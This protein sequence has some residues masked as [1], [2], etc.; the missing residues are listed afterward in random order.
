MGLDQLRIDWCLRAGV[1]T[2]AG[3]ITSSLYLLDG[4]MIMTSELWLIINQWMFLIYSY[5]IPHTMIVGRQKNII[6]IA[7][8]T[9]AVFAAEHKIY[10][11]K[12]GIE[13]PDRWACKTPAHNFALL[14]TIFF[15]KWINT[16]TQYY[17]QGSRAY[18]GKCASKW[19]CELAC[20]VLFYNPSSQGLGSTPGEI[21]RR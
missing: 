21:I 9:R 14:G 16:D 6:M 3:V 15:L 5:G 17:K 19:C 1:Y 8:F 11:E 18:I 2:S 7:S 12:T 13:D 20:K 4:W 10:R